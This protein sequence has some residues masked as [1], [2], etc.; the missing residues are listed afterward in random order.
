VVLVAAREGDMGDTVKFR[1]VLEFDDGSRARRFETT[2]QA[3]VNGPAGEAIGRAIGVALVATLASEEVLPEDLVLGLMEAAG[4]A[5][6]DV[7]TAAAVVQ[8]L[9]GGGTTGVTSPAVLVVDAGVVAGRA[10]D[11]EERARYLGA[12]REMAENTPD[13]RVANA[14]AGDGRG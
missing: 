13:V 9:A 8:R 12:L 4:E 6:D 2:E 11:A 10:A 5:A 1:L 7:L 14:P 3:G